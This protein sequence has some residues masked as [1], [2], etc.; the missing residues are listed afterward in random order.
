MLREDADKRR[1][2]YVTKR[3]ASARAVREKPAERE[4]RVK[5]TKT[6]L[7][8]LRALQSNA[9]LSNDVVGDKVSKSASVVSRR[10]AEL[11][12]AHVITGTHLTIDPAKVGLRTT[13]FMLV[14]LKQHG[15]GITTAFEREIEVMPNVIECA[16]VMG[17]WDY[18]LKLVV[19]DSEHHWAIHQQILGL[20]MVSRARSKAVIGTEHRKPIPLDGAL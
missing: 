14:R 5:L 12:K 2:K 8:I 1:A 3:R 16:P 9:W 4:S 20:P 7:E 13:A 17:K 19:R 11:V 18:L 10:L 15:D 6:D